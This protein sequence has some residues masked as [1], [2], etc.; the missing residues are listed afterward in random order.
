M[1]ATPKRPACEDSTVT[2]S[3][4]ESP[5]PD[6]TGINLA[7]LRRLNLAEDERRVVAQVQ[8]PRVNLG[9]SS[10]PGRAD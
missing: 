5:I 2:E 3:L 9:G 8:R 6:L 7:T 4:P 1:S 10:P